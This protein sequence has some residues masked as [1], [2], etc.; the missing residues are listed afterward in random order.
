MAGRRREVYIYKMGDPKS[1][2]NTWAKLYQVRII[3]FFTITTTSLV[4]PSTR[5]TPP[6]DDAFDAKLLRDNYRRLLTND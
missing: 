5:C 4:A 6:L 1:N 2:K 3:Y